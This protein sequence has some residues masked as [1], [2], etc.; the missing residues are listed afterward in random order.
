MALD[1][2]QQLVVD[3]GEGYHLVLAPPG[4]GKTHI[5]AERVRR[6]QAQGVAADE[7]LCLT[8]TN[9]AAREMRQRME[10]GGGETDFFIGNIHRF[11]SRFLFEE[12]LVPADTSIIDDEEAV[13]IL[14]DFIG[15][16]EERVVNNYNR[17]R[18]YQRVIFLSHLIEQREHGHG[19]DLWM[20]PEVEED[21]QKSANVEYAKQYARYKADN[22]FM[23]F[24]DLL[25]M[26]YDHC[27]ADSDIRRYSWIQIDEVQDLNAM[28][29]AIV[30]E[31]T[32]RDEATVMY[33]GDEQQAIFSFMG[34]KLETLLMLKERCRGHVYHLL[35]NHRSPSYL[36]Q[37]FNDYAASQLKIDR[38]LLPTT[39]NNQKA[40]HHELR[41]LHSDTI[42]SE[43]IEVV[44]QARQLLSVHP[45]ET[46]A[47]I[48]LS[49]ADAD[50]ISNHMT[51][52]EINHFKVSG[53]DLFDTREMKLLLAHLNVVTN[54]RNM[55]CWARIMKGFNVFESNP[56]ARRFLRKLRQLAISPVDLLDYSPS[57]LDSRL[58]TYVADFV[59]TYEKQELVV[60]DTETT[61]TNYQ[62]DDVIEIS[63]MRVCKGEVV[64]EPLDIYVRTDKEIP[65]ML[66][67]KPN[68]MKIIY[69]QKEKEGQLLDKE[70]ALKLFYDYVGDRPVVGHNVMF[71]VEMIK[72]QEVGDK[73]QEGAK[74]REGERARI[75]ST[76]D[77]R[78]STIFDTLKLTHLLDPNLHSYKLESLLAEY[79]LEGE[80]SHQAIDDVAATV[81]LLNY[82][83]RTAVGRISEQQAF[84]SHPRVIPIVNNF[85]ANYGTL[86]HQ[87]LSHLYDGTR[88]EALISELRE[89]HQQLLD[90]RYIKEVKKLDY[91]LEYLRMDVLADAPENEML[92]LQLGRCIME[93]NTMK[94]ADFC[95]S[96]SLKERVYVTTVHK[97]KGLE[98]DNVIVFDAV[99]GRYPNYHNTH[100]QQDAEDARKLYV[101]MSRAK[102]RLIIAYSMTRVDYHGQV[103]QQEL[104]PFM[105]AIL[106]YFD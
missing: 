69:H 86:Y 8:F 17:W 91:L 71:D 23:D 25:I 76:L 24:E 92:A 11:C 53:R 32:A 102:K 2:S 97:A 66:G 94:E 30:D 39:D 1:Q 47:V 51:Q 73:E 75:P 85:R 106:T 4:C 81:S 90:E 59:K 72:E 29:L 98:F 78:L 68:P 31:L 56:L 15:E 100:P 38:E 84:L 64:G 44:G 37:V 57:T 99:A 12:N 58:S 20:H 95:N 105:N 74:E 3:A 48:V 28:Q 10:H 60:F 34:A 18:E 46:T 9:R 26:T 22:H 36:L 82:L 41:I 77:P 79:H 65:A 70:E 87:T 55:I 61:G 52:M 7:M 5:L 27:C 104:T 42:D 33:L 83:Y 103:R 54:E 43:I 49:N 80:N 16:D 89:V 6:A 50:R 67:S 13:S 62:E 14:A 96:R 21:L 63:A 45:D 101:A 93:L 19:R 35:Q 88:K 40:E